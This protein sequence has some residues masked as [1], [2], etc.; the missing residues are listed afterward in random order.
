MSRSFRTG[1]VLLAVLGLLCTLIAISV[2]FVPD[3]F[4]PDAQALIGTFGTGMGLMVVALATVGLGSRQTWPWLVLW[5]LPAFFASHVAL[6]G[7]LA[8]DGVFALIAAG[9][10]VL[11]RPRN[12]EAGLAAA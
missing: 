8:P 1:Q 3:P 7:T 10:L 6:L 12:A 4:E 5:A 11:T 2:F 9:A